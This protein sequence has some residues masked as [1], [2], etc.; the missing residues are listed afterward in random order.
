MASRSSTSTHSPRTAMTKPSERSREELP[1]ESRG[2]GESGT[3]RVPGPAEKKHK[4]M[5]EV[6][7]TGRQS[8]Q[9]G[10]PGAGKSRSSSRR[11][12]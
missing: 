12:A 8:D 7:Q 1:S 10:R 3:E 6:R 5:A 11:G 9:G 4:N 2:R